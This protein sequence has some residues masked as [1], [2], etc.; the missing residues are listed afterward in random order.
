VLS[1]RERQIA[2]LAADGLRNANVAA[3]LDIAE[4][5]VAVHLKRIYGKL[6]VASRV[7]LATRWRG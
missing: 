3:R 4:A 7:E 5:T 2:A 1:R 6:G